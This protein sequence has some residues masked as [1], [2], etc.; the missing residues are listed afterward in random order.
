M[1][2]ESLRL[3]DR[4][5]TWL[6]RWRSP[7]LVVSLLLTVAGVWPSSHLQF[8]V[9][10]TNMFPP[11]DPVLL[12]YQDGL[13]LFGGAEL[14]VVAYTDPELLTAD[15]LRRLHQFSADLP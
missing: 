4:I 13:K 2:D 1:A 12:A 14:V 10:I 7:L 11:N 8:D 9:A 15:G 3:T 6:V 5:A